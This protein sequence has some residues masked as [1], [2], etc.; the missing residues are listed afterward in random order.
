M[1]FVS[2][3]E[4][5]HQRAFCERMLL[6]LSNGITESFRSPLASALSAFSVKEAHHES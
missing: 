1:L 4:A 5:P 6:A 3:A 2:L